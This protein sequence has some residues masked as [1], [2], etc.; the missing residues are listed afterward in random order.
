MECVSARVRKCVN[1][2]VLVEGVFMVCGIR[3]IRGQTRSTSLRVTKWLSLCW[4]PYV[5]VR[6]GSIKGR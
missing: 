1:G 4:V 6:V 2:Q 5:C 3:L